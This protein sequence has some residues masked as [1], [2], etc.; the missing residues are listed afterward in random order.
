MD[1]VCRLCYFWIADEEYGY[2]NAIKD[3]IF[4]KNFIFYDK[5]NIEY[6]NHNLNIKIN[7]SYISNFYSIDNEKNNIEITGI[8][9]KNGS[10][11]TALLSFINNC[12]NK[13]ISF[14]KKYIIIFEID[15]NLNIF[16][17]NC[18][19]ENLEE[20]HKIDYIKINNSEEDFEYSLYSVNRNMSTIY[21]SQTFNYRNNLMLEKSDNS[22]YFNISLYNDVKL[23]FRYDTKSS[24]DYGINEDFWDTRFLDEDLK[25][26]NNYLARKNLKYFL[27]CNNFD[28]KYVAL[29]V[30]F[31]SSGKIFF[32]DNI[33]EK[34]RFY[35]K[36]NNDVEH[37]EI[38]EFEQIVHVRPTQIEKDIYKKIV[39]K[40]ENEKKDRN[41]V[42][43]MLQF[44]TIDF[45]FQALYGILNN[46]KYINYTNDIISKIK[47]N[48]KTDIFDII[49]EI[50][51]KI[52]YYA[53]K[54]NDLKIESFYLTIKKLNSDCMEIFETIEKLYNSNS[55]KFVLGERRSSSHADF[56]C[57]KSPHIIVEKTEFKIL[58]KVLENDNNLFFN[59][60]KIIFQGLSS[61]QQ[62]L[63]DMFSKFY[64]IKD[65]IETNSI[66]VIM[67]EP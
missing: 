41:K 21:Y 56:I 46:K 15:G 19:I 51:Q 44:A 13:N 29:E 33:S 22:N 55:T 12:L 24:G 34:W 57:K 65:K 27:K 58:E 67:D 25:I 43:Y 39:Q 32:I 64:D 52:I 16:H 42:K 45:Y 8:I 1:N 28:I 63:L 6:S 7:E 59:L 11:K 10:G 66:L 53:D 23:N 3:N 54:I 60:F 26:T 49:K 35:R 48:N 30:P 14:L 50:Q 36:F 20:L 2:S 9:G 62:A 37:E 31:Y 38:N 47:I 40:I 5:Y 18:Y 4:K 17:K 61:G